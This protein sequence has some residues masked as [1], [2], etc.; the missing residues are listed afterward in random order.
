MFHPAGQW[1]WQPMIDASLRVGLDSGAVHLEQILAV[2]AVILIYFITPY[3]TRASANTG[4]HKTLVLICQHSVPDITQE[5]RVVYII[6][7]AV[8]TATIRPLT[9]AMEQ[10]GKEEAQSTTAVNVDRTQVVEE[11]S[12]T[13]I[14]VVVMSNV[15]VLL[16]VLVRVGQLLERVG[17]GWTALRAVA[18]K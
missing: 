2:C 14:V 13:S 16:D 15:C 17:N 8:T 7:P 3:P 6:G 5:E 18:M 1:M 12:T 9:L 4:H 11:T 10:L